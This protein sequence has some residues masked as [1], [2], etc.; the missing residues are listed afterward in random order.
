MKS[1]RR[2]RRKRIIEKILKRKLNGPRGPRAR[3]MKLNGFAEF[4]KAPIKLLFPWGRNTGVQGGSNGIVFC[5]KP[6]R[7]AYFEAFP[8]LLNEV[9]PTRTRFRRHRY[10]STSGEKIILDPSGWETI[11]IRG[12]GKTIRHAE[13]DCWL[14]YM[15][16]VR[17]RDHVMDRRKRTDGYCYCV[18]CGMSDTL[19]EP[20]TSCHVCGVKTNWCHFE[21]NSE[22]KSRWFCKSHAKQQW[23]DPDLSESSKRY[24]DMFRRLDE[25]KKVNPENVL[26]ILAGKGAT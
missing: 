23:D 10:T 7:T 21:F 3:E 5:D 1:T 19:L 24:V 6:Y 20:M 15:R 16:I 14:D 9:I 2:N 22:P 8:K 11:F 13:I 18:K 26:E 17:C 4:R 25:A 12:E